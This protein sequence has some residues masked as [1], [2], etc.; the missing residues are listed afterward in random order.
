MR[1]PLAQAS[2]GLEGDGSVSRYPSHGE[3][4][5]IPGN[6]IPEA[7]NKGKGGHSRVSKAIFLTKV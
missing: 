2:M 1:E 3:L 5:Y 7:N 6:V 4:G